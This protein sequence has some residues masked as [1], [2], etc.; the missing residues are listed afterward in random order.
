MSLARVAS[1]FEGLGIVDG[2]GRYVLLLWAAGGFCL[3][4]PLLF[5]SLLKVPCF[6][7]LRVVDAKGV[8]RTW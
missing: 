5:V 1:S 2:D 7:R 3:G 8:E 6:F 4:N